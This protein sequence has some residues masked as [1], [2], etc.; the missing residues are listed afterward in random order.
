MSSYVARLSRALSRSTARSSTRSNSCSSHARERPSGNGVPCQLEKWHQRRIRGGAVPGAAGG[1]REF[2]QG[3][4]AQ[5]LC[6]MGHCLCRC[7]SQH[8]VLVQNDT[9]QVPTD[10]VLR[11]AR[12]QLGEVSDSRTAGGPS[13]V[14]QPTPSS[15][16]CS[17]PLAPVL[18]YPADERARAAGSIVVPSA[19]SGQ[20]DGDGGRQLAGPMAPQNASSTQPAAHARRAAKRA[21]LL[22][23]SEDETIDLDDCSRLARLLFAKRACDLVR[24]IVCGCNAVTPSAAMTA[25][26][27]HLFRFVGTG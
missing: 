7:V 21:A 5:V 12:R 4:A 11:A 6:L 20:L 3:M 19:G 17:R 22:A 1:A 23:L 13:N 25:T 8:Y 9:L 18:E 2:V 10:S 26:L 24:C 16:A 14:D 27:C 15:A